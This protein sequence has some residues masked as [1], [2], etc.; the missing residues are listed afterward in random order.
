MKETLYD[1]AVIG[2]GT[3]GLVCAAGA[4]GLG[5]RVALIERNRLGG[6]CLYTGCVPSKA[7]L[8]GARRSGEFAAAMAHVAASIAAIAPHDSP[9]RLSRL[10]VEVIFG[11]AAFSGRD[12]IRAGERVVRFRRAVIAT[13]SRA[14]VPPIP[15]IE[16][17]GY[18]TNDTLFSLTAQPRTLAILGGGPAGC[19][20][21]QAF[22][23]L[24]TNVTLLEAGPRIL[25]RDDPDAAAVLS[26]RLTRDG[27]TVLTDV[28]V[29]SA[30]REGGAIVLAHDGGRIVADAL[31]VAA[32]RTPNVD[33][34]DLAAAGV[35]TGADGIHVDDYF[36]TT[37]RR[38]FA[39]GDVCSRWRFT[40][41]ADAMSRA[42]VENALFL[43]RRRGTRLLIPWC[44]FTAP[45]IAHV[46]V[47]AVDA[48]RAGLSTITVPLA[49]VDRATLDGDTDGFVRLH[50]A[51]GRLR[52]ATIVAPHAGELI[53]AVALLISTG[54]TMR[55]LAS[56]IFPYPTVSVAL[57]Q[58]GDAYRRAS[59][60]PGVRAALRAW[61]ALRR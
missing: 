9:E 30:A 44:T 32:G 5:A 53:G 13:G 42:V 39:S 59:L 49:E 1:L 43:P 27:V 45:E 60:T 37:N 3:A 61:F 12:A 29:S 18:L 4:A 34:L 26:R 7:L 51:N 35:R 58:A 55:D 36:R 38:I 24:G 56:A 48:A 22:A 40:H 6:E 57:R 10:G 2:G 31:F 28:H 19:E 17:T 33:G 20:M 41:A 23:C 14:S 8:H 15:G 52:G 50:H 21:A 16:G 46:G 25:P 47:D 11:D 54:A